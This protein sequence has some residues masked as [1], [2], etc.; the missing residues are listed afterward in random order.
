[1]S[2]IEWKLA[3][4]S[5]KDAVCAST[6]NVPVMNEDVFFRSSSQFRLWSFTP[7][8]L[9]SMRHAT[10]AHAAA[11][12]QAAFRRHAG[13]TKASTVTEAD[14]S[15]NRPVECLTTKEELKLVRYY[16]GTLLKMAE[17]FNMPAEAKVRAL[18]SCAAPDVVGMQLTDASQATAVQYFKRFYLTNSIMTYAPKTILKTALFFATKTEHYYVP[19]QD[20]AMR[21]ANTSSQEILASEFILTQGLRFT[22]DVRHPLRAHMGAMIE[23]EGIARGNIMLE[24]EAGTAPVPPKLLDKIQRMYQRSREILKTD[25]QIADVYF[26]FTPSQ[27][28]FASLWIAD[29]EL[30]EWYLGTKTHADAPAAQ[31]KILATIKNCAAQLLEIGGKRADEVSAEEK[32]DLRALT[33]KLAR[34]MDP[35]KGDL[36]GLQRAK[37]EGGEG[38]DAEKAVKKRKSEREGLAVEG[39]ALFG[40]ELKNTTGA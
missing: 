5:M 14:I 6:P 13:T 2:S 34:C 20:F 40:P 3:T 23:L 7:T 33:K 25:A 22:F 17:E 19:V 30:A 35:E 16:C 32:K 4:L 29:R 26:H 11:R 9:Q 24:G 38:L 39:E 12:V 15:S 36:V 1:M 18:L 8:S 21:I 31:E 28:M 10:N 37:R 27:I